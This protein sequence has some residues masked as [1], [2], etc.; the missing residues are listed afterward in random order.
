MKMKKYQYKIPFRNIF[1]QTLLFLIAYSRIAYGNGELNLLEDKSTRIVALEN[2]IITSFSIPEVN[3]IAKGTAEKY[4]QDLGMGL[5]SF[6]L[7][8]SSYQKN[9]T[10]NDLYFLNI[11]CIPKKASTSSSSNAMS[12]SSCALTATASNSSYNAY[13]TL[14]QTH[15]AI[16]DSL[17]REDKKVEQKEELKDAKNSKLERNTKQAEVELP[18]CFQKLLSKEN[19][20]NYIT[21]AWK[22]PQAN[23][24]SASELKSMLDAREKVVTDAYKLYQNTY[25]ALHDGRFAHFL[26]HEIRGI[27]YGVPKKDRLGLDLNKIAEKL[28]GNELLYI[29]LKDP[30]DKQEINTSLIPINEFLEDIEKLEHDG[31]EFR[32]MNEKEFYELKNRY[33]YSVNQ[34]IWEFQRKKRNDE[35]G[36]NGTDSKR[37]SGSKKSKDK[38]EASEFCIYHPRLNIKVS[39]SEDKGA[40]SLINNP[41]TNINQYSPLYGDN[42]FLLVMAKGWNHTAAFAPKGSQTPIFNRLLDHKDL[43]V[44]LMDMR[45]GMTAL[46]YA[47]LRGDNPQVIKKLLEKN[48]NP[49]LKDYQGRTA[50]DL[51]DI[52]HQEMQNI[53]KEATG[54]PD[55]F[56]NN[57]CETAT[58]PSPSERDQNILQIR[59]LLKDSIKPQ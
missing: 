44:N 47:C 2:K 56:K 48:A 3:F 4:C 52:G 23:K 35:D 38:E 10:S 27:Y 41:L 55:G 29:Y 7:D 53:I 58:V 24:L 30:N 39:N 6:D 31:K 34:P 17:K 37:N 43:Q 51:L 19:F 50:A 57:K 8:W 46:H 13:T 5:K 25:H 12:S 14:A 26:G 9:V 54:S 15:S 22:T 32:G 49:L 11:I 1:Q 45:N 21:Q 20:S 42:P 59:K 33:L 36:K 18:R 40:L 16:A 28:H